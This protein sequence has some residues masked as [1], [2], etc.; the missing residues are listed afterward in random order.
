[1][2]KSLC[3]T[4]DFT[5]NLTCPRGH[6]HGSGAEAHLFTREDID[7]LMAY[8]AD[9]G[10][11]RHEWILGNNNSLYDADSPLGYDLMRVAC[12]AAHRYGMRFDVVLK[13]FDAGGYGLNR[14]L[15]IGLP[16]QAGVP[17][18][19]ERDGIVHGVHPFVAAHPEMRLEREASSAF[20]PGG[21]VRSIR[22]IAHE[23][24][25]TG[26]QPGDLSIWTS[27]DASGASIEPYTGPLSWRETVEYRP[28]LRYQDLSCRVLHL[29]GLELPASAQ[30]IVIRCER[31]GD[32]RLFNHVNHVAELV[33]A[34]GRFIPC[35]PVPGPITAGDREALH[36]SALLGYNRYLSHPDVRGV[37][38]DEDQSAALCQATNRL[39]STCAAPGDPTSIELKMEPGQ[40]LV[41]MRGK[42]RYLG[43]ALNPAYPE[44]RENW[45]DQVRFCIQRDVDGVNIRTQGH[46]WVV[47][48]WAYG[49]NPPTMAR[50][51]QEGN[52]AEV[53]RVNGLA[54]TQFLRDAA[55]LLH[56]AGKEMG[57]HVYTTMIGTED[58]P[59]V[60]YHDSLV[61]RNIEWPWETWIREIADYVEFR[62]AFTM[63]PENLRRAVD[64]IGLTAR[65]AGIPFIYQS[66]RANGVVTFDGPHNHLGWEIDTVVRP[67][68]DIGVYNLYETACFTRF[69]ADGRFEG[70]PRMAALVR[71]LW[72]GRADGRK[73][74]A[75]P[76]SG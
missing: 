62:G 61:P 19:E 75:R 45:L 57:V 35:M 18:I 3:C 49:F 12:D 15:P 44:V 14:K 34:D 11:D 63:R 33:Q 1:M 65:E 37:L 56:A 69:D 43:S 17:F 10:A 38:D 36:R 71:R 27:S 64:L 40:Q 31:P 73:Q 76:D 58:R 74:S 16:K 25:A 66:S 13:P 32:G 4:T 48:P 72:A 54:Y 20:D 24:A 6:E 55:L 67:H 29:D 7:A 42:L 46:N 39:R 9:M 47:D 50:V 28:L 70:S 26:I 51:Q 41:L 60:W 30:F 2:H 8:C 5:D 59:G 52:V 68:P 53:A 21:P 23:T 22:L